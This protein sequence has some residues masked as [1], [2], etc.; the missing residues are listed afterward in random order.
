[1][2]TRL[3][4][5]ILLAVFMLF[6]L[7]CARAAPDGA[8]APGGALAPVFATK[9]GTKYHRDGCPSLSKSRVA[10]SLSEALDRGL[11]PCS[12]CDPPG[13]L[14]GPAGRYRIDQA[15][16]TSSAEA[17][18][19]LMTAARVSAVVDGDTVKVDILGTPPSGLKLREKVR[20]LGVDT[21][22]TVHPN[23]GVERF[24]KESSAYT[25]ERLLGREVLLAFDWDLRDG[26]G[27]LLAYIYLS[28]GRCFNAE[29]VEQ[30][31]AHAYLKYPFAFKDEFGALQA[32]A[33]A[34]GKGLWAGAD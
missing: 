28:D 24:G 21:P 31:Y 9:T 7:S 4:F 25:R 15:S 14:P 34:G 2:M 26:F 19:S 10:L 5:P 1:M 33:R 30:G 6:P 3:A 12:V 23:K 22:E 29:L 20:L 16:L 32:G 8:S 13:R 18:L 11:E 17:D 27:R